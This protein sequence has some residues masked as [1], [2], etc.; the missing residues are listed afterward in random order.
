M[1]YVKVSGHFTELR[2]DQNAK[3]LCNPRTT[4]K[5]NKNKNGPRNNL[6]VSLN[7]NSDFNKNM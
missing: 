6:L 3:L 2:E 4:L 7:K 1:T 5:T